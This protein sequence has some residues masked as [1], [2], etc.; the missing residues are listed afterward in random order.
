MEVPRDGIRSGDAGDGLAS[1]AFYEPSAGSSLLQ[2]YC[3][4][5]FPSPNNRFCLLQKSLTFPSNIFCHF[6]HRS[7]QNGDLPSPTPEFPPVQP[8]SAVAVFALFIALFFLL[9]PSASG[10][11]NATVSALLPCCPRDSPARSPRRYL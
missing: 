2:A 9:F 7:G 5:F 11:E 8:D 4:F 10:P 3:C 1:D 6:H